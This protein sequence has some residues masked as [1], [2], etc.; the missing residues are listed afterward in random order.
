MKKITSEL[1]IVFKIDGNTTLNINKEGCITTDEYA[2]ILV[3][4][5]G[6]NIK[7]E[8]TTVEEAVETPK[9]KVKK[10]KK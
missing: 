1:D 6:V 3:E 8:D 2:K 4:R 7:V 5:L 10:A 9:T